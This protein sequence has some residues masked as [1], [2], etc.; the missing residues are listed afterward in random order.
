MG[1]ALDLLRRYRPGYWDSKDVAKV[2]QLDLLPMRCPKERTERTYRYQGKDWKHTDLV[3]WINEH[4]EP[5]PLKFSGGQWVPSAPIPEGWG[6]NPSIAQKPMPPSQYLEPACVF[7]KARILDQIET[8][9][10]GIPKEAWANKSAETKWSEIIRTLKF[11]QYKPG[12]GISG[13]ASAGAFQNT[14]AALFRQTPVDWDAIVKAMGTKLA[15]EHPPGQ[16]GEGLSKYRKN[17]TLVPP[18]YIPWDETSLTDWLDRFHPKAPGYPGAESHEARVD[19]YLRAWLADQEKRQAQYLKTDVRSIAPINVRVPLQGKK[20]SGKLIKKI[21]GI[22]LIAAAATGVFFLGK[23][24]VGKIGSALAAKGAGAAG[25]GGASVTGAAASAAGTAASAGGLVSAGTGVAGKVLGVYNKI[26]A[27]ARAMGKDLPA[28]P[29][30]LSG[31]AFV[32]WAVRVGAQEFMAREQRRMT[33]AEEAAMRRE[34]EAM[35]REWLDAAGNVESDPSDTVAPP[36]VRKKIVEQRESRE[37][38]T[39]ILLYGALGIGV[40]LALG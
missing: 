36:D 15:L 1:Y 17:P 18:V 37:T 19:A 22:A 23:M 32:D 24:A 5:G 11:A 27:A 40:V 10:L 9:I 16:F 34:I 7:D 6:Y 38:M 28:L 4:W 12:A 8:P 13:Q 30:D 25:A 2:K 26:A 35:Q 20:E 39:R 3:R 31:G 21:A 14:M 29:T 33:R